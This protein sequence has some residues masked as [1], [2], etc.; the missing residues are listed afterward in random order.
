MPPASATVGR[1]GKTG[2]RLPLP[3]PRA[4]I[5]PAF[6]CGIDVLK[7][8]NIKSTWPPSTSISAGA[9][10]SW[11]L[12]HLEV[13][14]GRLVE[15]LPGHVPGPAMTRVAHGHLPGIRPYIREQL[16]DRLRR[17]RAL[18]TRICGRVQAMLPDEIRDRV[19]PGIPHDEG[20]KDEGVCRKKQHVT[21]GRSPLHKLDADQAARAGTI[22]HDGLFAESLGKRR[23]Q[24]T[25]DQI[26][27][28]SADVGTM[29]STVFVGYF[30]SA[31]RSSALP[32]Q[33]TNAITDTT[34]NSFF[35]FASPAY[36]KRWF[37]LSRTYGII[38]GSQEQSGLKT[39]CM[40]GTTYI[41][42][43]PCR[44]REA[45]ISPPPLCQGVSGAPKAGI[46]RPRGRLARVRRLSGDLQAEHAACLPCRR[47]DR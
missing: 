20:C 28:A 40:R 43:R 33:S 30:C 9:L 1:S 15:H 10:P 34:A 14:A 12:Q 41:P 21:V 22:V 7:V 2:E 42:I 29:I 17:K 35:M 39:G 4:R 27:V 38:S 19:I 36:G 13:A 45:Y 46:R 31:A 26:E 32:A 25:G 18:T 6:T 11:E 47:L 5:L 24:R 44:V 16:L 37:C 23:R 3:S 8:S